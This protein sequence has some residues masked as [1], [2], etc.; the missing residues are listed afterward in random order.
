MKPSNYYNR[1]LDLIVGRAAIWTLAALIV[2]C[3]VGA[4]ML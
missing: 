1:N 4:L 3:V 2:A